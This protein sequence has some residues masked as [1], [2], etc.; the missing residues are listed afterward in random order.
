MARKVQ[1]CFAELSLAATDLQVTV[2]GLCHMVDRCVCNN[3]QLWFCALSFD[4]NVYFTLRRLRQKW[5]FVGLRF[6]P[7][8][9][10]EPHWVSFSVPRHLWP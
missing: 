1:F 10:P 9:N 2:S 4:L 5:D 7:N 3:I 6:L 8:R